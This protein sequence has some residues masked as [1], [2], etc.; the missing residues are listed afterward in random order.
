[1]PSDFNTF[2]RRGFLAASAATVG[3]AAIGQT[4]NSTEIESAI[5]G[6]VTRN[7]ASF[8]ALDWR[9]YFENTTGGAILCDIESRALHYWS[10][11][12]SIYKLYPTSVPLS[13]DLTRRGRTEVIRKVEGPSWPKP[14]RFSEIK[15]DGAELL[16]PDPSFFE[17][18]VLS[19]AC[20]PRQS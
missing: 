14:L 11:D 16:G 5:G 6:G 4:E 13:E 12:Q 3:T 19:R 1:M 20:L 10:E 2:S 9:P 8:R 15:A 7:T 17:V 18:R